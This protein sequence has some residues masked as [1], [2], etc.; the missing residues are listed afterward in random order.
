GLL[1]TFFTLVASNVGATV[2]LVPL[3]MNM[4]LK[5]GADPCIAALVVGIAAS[6]TFILP[7]HQVNA[8]IMRPGGYKTKDYVKAGTGMTVIFAGVTL[9]MLWLF[10]G[11]RF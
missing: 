2:L 3:A 5:T 8:L 10:Y 4:A 7:T 9:F 11:V 1:T 6:N